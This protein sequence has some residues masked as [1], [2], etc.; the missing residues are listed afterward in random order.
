MGYTYQMPHLVTLPI[1]KLNNNYSIPQLGLGVWKIDI[2]KVTQVVLQALRFGY[3]HVDTAK[4]YGNEQGVGQ[5]IKES[6]LSRDKIFITT[7]LAPQNIFN[8]QKAFDESLQRLNLDYVDLYLIHWPILGWQKAWSTLEKIYKDGRAKAIGVSNFG[9]NQ[10]QELK[11]IGTI[12]P[13]VNQIELSPFLYR[14]ELINY[15][16]QEKITVE[17][18]SPLTRGRRIGDKS[19]LDIAKTYHMSPAQILIRWG[20]QHGFVMIP[21]SENPAHIQENFAVFDF[22][23]NS[24]DMQKLDSLNENYSALFYGLHRH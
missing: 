18:Y 1:V 14:K 3:R 9:I 7:K 20:L 11:K 12:Q 16:Q 24:K 15:C 4:A 13:A 22:Q 19:I 8:P 2:T 21:K 17:A 23:I 6:G 10:L 5:A